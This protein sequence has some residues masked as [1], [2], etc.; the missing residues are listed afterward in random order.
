MKVQTEAVTIAD[1]G[2]ES[3]VIDLSSRLLRAIVFPAGWVTADA[4]FKVATTET[5][6]YYPVND[7]DGARWVTGGAASQIS[8]VRLE[9]AESL[10]W[11]KI[12]SVD[13]TDATAES[14]TGGPLTVTLLTE[15]R[16]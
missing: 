1:N 9:L 15:N 4:A 16:Y 5:G 7:W 10:A 6:T 3:T 11:T 12:E 2:T 13:T 14:Q 8:V